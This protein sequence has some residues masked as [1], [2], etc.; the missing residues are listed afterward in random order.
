MVIYP[1]F[2]ISLILFWN[3]LVM[4]CMWYLSIPCS[5]LALIFGILG[6]KKAKKGMAIAGIVTGGIALAIWLFLFIGAFS[7]GF[8][9]GF[10]ETMSS[11]Y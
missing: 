11:M 3:A 2:I 5:I 10:T 8:I 6:V 1:N 7:Y 4:W 9:Q